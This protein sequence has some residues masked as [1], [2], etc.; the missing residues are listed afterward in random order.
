MKS[1]MLKNLLLVGLLIIGCAGCSPSEESA[2]DLFRKGCRWDEKKNY[3]EA[4]KYYRQA[5]EKGHAGAQNNLGVCYKKGEGVEPDD[6]KAAYWYRKAAEQG[7]KEAQ[8]NLGAYYAVEENN[9]AEA[10]KWYR[11]AAEQ[12]DAVAQCNLGWRYKNGEGVPKDMKKAVYWY[13]KAAEQGN[14]KA[15]EALKKLGK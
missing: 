11:K 7:L 13:R 12:G 15:Q 8:N 2:D 6:A 4:A 10:V 5:A 14:A 1:S 3:D 9:Y